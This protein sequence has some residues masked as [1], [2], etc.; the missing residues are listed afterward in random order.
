MAVIFH[1][2]MIYPFGYYF[3]VFIIFALTDPF[4]WVYVAVGIVFYFHVDTFVY[5]LTKDRTKFNLELEA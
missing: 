2:L 4:L 1:I 3:V 5:I